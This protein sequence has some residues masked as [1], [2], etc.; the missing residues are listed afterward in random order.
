VALTDRPLSH[1]AVCFVTVVLILV[2]S[3]GIVA[4]V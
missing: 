2:I 4:F 3:N 1:D